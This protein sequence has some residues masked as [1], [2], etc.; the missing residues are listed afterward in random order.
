MTLT[1][2][3]QSIDFTST[4]KLIITYMLCNNNRNFSY[5]LAELQVIFGISY[6]TAQKSMKNLTK[7]QIVSAEL[8]RDNSPTSYAI[9]LD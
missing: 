1:E 4:E 5:S 9:L 2:F 7:Q 6:L 3:V 8:I